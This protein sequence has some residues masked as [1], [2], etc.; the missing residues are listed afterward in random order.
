[1]SYYDFFFGIEEKQT[2]Y[3]YHSKSFRE[4]EIISLE[5]LVFILGITNLFLLIESL[6]C[7]SIFIHP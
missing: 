4:Q 3:S 7:G 5:I 6:D 1:M 2:K